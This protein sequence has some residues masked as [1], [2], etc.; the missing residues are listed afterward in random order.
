MKVEREGSQADESSRGS[1]FKRSL[2]GIANAT[3][4]LD[5]HMTSKLCLLPPEAG[6]GAFLRALIG[7]VKQ[8]V[9]CTAAWLP[10]RRSL[11]G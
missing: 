11:I 4:A 1:S 10:F 9:L 3:N 7:C 6:E 2:T 8:S 5:Y